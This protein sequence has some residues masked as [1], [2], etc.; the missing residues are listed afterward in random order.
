MSG[1]RQVRRFRFAG[2]DTVVPPNSR[3]R[4]VTRSRLCNPSLVR[5]LPYERMDPTTPWPLA[6]NLRSIRRPRHCPPFLFPGG[7]QCRAAAIVHRLQAC[8]WGEP[9]WAGAGNR[10]GYRVLPADRPG[11]VGLFRGAGWSAFYAGG[12]LWIAAAHRRRGLSTRSSWGRR[13]KQ[14]GGILPPGV[15]VVGYTPASLAAHLAAHAREAILTALAAGATVSG[16]V[17]RDVAPQGQ[18]SI[19][20]Q[21]PYP[22]VEQRSA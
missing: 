19:A 9:L 17:L 21:M 3:G 12:Y 1:L 2:R 11:T 14:G 18:D 10:A 15:V 8:R 4:G 16:A 20:G 13:S 22:V 6:K 5:F 7:G